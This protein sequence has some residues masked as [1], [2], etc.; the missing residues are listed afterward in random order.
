MYAIA[1]V[2]NSLWRII[3]AIPHFISNLFPIYVSYTL[4]FDKLDLIPTI[5]GYLIGFLS[6]IIVFSSIL[7]S[8]FKGNRVHHEV[9]DLKV[10]RDEVISFQLALIGLFVTLVFAGLDGQINIGGAIAASIFLFLIVWRL[11]IVYM[12]IWAIAFGLIPYKLINSRGQEFIILMFVK[13]F[14]RGGSLV[15]AEING[16]V[17]VFCRGVRS[18]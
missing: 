16:N 3:L 12:N 8:Y 10:A 4:L 7:Y 15:G 1:S 13:D 17:H 2:A 5:Y 9:Y 6:T 18:A 14:Q 11:D